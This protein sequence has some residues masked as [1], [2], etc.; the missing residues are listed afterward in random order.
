MNKHEELIYNFLHKCNFV[1][2]KIEQLDGMLIPREMLLCE[3]KYND[4]SQNILDLKKSDYDMSTKAIINK[5]FR[6]TGLTFD[7]LNDLADGDLFNRMERGGF[8]TGRGKKIPRGQMR[9][10]KMAIY[11]RNGDIKSF[12][13]ETR[14]SAIFNQDILYFSDY[15]EAIS[16]A[17]IGFGHGAGYYKNFYKIERGVTIG[18]TTEAIANYVA[19]T[20]GP[21]AKV[22]KKLMSKYA[23]N[24]T[25]SFDEIF[26]SLAKGD[27]EAVAD[28][29]R[30]KALGK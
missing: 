29:L 4:L 15:M 18:H 25:K 7:D 14:G 8:L 28:F 11:L 3:K 17:R 13:T 16:N 5:E 12:L 24:M 2:D 26:K 22:F 30:G 9:L 27:T 20:G 19:L 10:K 6:G 23:P 21:R 1:F